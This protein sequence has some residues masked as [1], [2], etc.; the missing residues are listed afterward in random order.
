M[1]FRSVLLAAAASLLTGVLVAYA[2]IPG[3][4]STL[5]TVFTL[6]FDNATQKQTYSASWAF[7]PASSATDVLTIQGS[8]TK[9]VNV[10]RIYVNGVAT[11]SVNA[12][13]LLVRR[14]TADTSGSTSG[15]ALTAASYNT[16][17]TTASGSAATA[18]VEIYT[19]NP[20]EPASYQTIIE[21]WFTWGNMTTTQS[22][23][24]DLYFGAGG[25]PLV[26]QGIAQTI[27]LNLNGITFSGAQLT[28]TVEWT[29]E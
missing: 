7:S 6:A 2:Q 17:N 3:V 9:K 21:R 25:S 23:D 5:N 1:K 13:A 20:V 16:S 15:T 29:E 12:L 8:A 19:T 27:A 24:L 28:V 26:L 11:T 22:K 10:R 18:I 14:A 4:N